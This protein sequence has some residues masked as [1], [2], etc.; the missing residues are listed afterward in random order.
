[1]ENVELDMVEECANDLN[2]PEHQNE[3]SPM[4]KQMA[5]ERQDITGLKCL[6]GVSGKEM[7]NEL[8][9]HGRSTRKN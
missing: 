1:M 8:K 9:I 5:R 2:D 3:I 7:R 6:K 4:A